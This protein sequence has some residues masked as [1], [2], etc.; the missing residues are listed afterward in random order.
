MPWMEIRAAVLGAVLLTAGCP[1]DTAPPPPSAVSLTDGAG[2]TAN[3]DIFGMDVATDATG[4]VHVVWVER[5]DVYGGSDGHE[6]VV[7]R[8]GSGMPLRWGP[9]IVLAEG[10]G[11]VPPAVVAGDHGVHVLAGGWLHHWWWPAGTAAFRDLGE[12]LGPRDVGAETLDAIASGNGITIAYTPAYGRGDANVYGVRWTAGDGVRRLVIANFPHGRAAASARPVL[13]AYGSRLLLLWANSSFFDASAAKPGV[14]PESRQDMDIHVAWSTDDGLTWGKPDTVAHLDSAWISGLASAGT[15]EAPAVA[16]T[17]FGLFASRLHAGAWTPPVQ[18]A[19][20]AP[21]F[22][23]GSADTAAVDAVR[24]DGHLTVAWVDAR[25]RRSDRRWW[26][27]LGGIPWS[28]DPD[29]D[30]N[31]VLVARDVPQ[32]ASAAAAIVPLRLTAPESMTRDVRVV[33]RGKQLLVF[34]SGRAR[35]HKAPNDMGAPPE[36]TL[37]NLPCD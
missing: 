10:G 25:Y 8:R 2:L 3:D 21:G 32:S 14:I 7:Y 35:V 6:R 36:L 18:V 29:W 30:N 4:A 23:A 13:H 19:P 33:V 37:A 5:T 15:D 17:A 31:D 28:D 11:F 20:H 34:R 26:N 16:F 22:L 9:R 1:A 27:P 24:C 12:I